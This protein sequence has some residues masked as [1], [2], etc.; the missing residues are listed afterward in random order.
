[1]WGGVWGLIALS[2]VVGGTLNHWL[3]M[4]IHECT[5]ELAARTHRGNRWLAMLAGLP[6]VAPA[7]MAFWHHHQAHHAFLGIEGGD[8]DLPS[9]GEVGWVGN[10]SLRKATWLLTLPLTAPFTRG[11]MVP[12]KYWERIN[13]AV[14]LAANVAIVYWLGWRA[15]AYFA[16]STFFG[17]GLHPAAAHW[18]HEHYT[19]DGTQE[20][21]SYYGPLNWLTFNVGY[22]TEH[23]DLPKIPGWKLPELHRIARPFYA[24]QQSHRSWLGVL[25]RFITRPETSHAS[26]ITRTVRTWQNAR[27]PKAQHAQRIKAAGALNHQDSLIAPPAPIETS[28]SLVTDLSHHASQSS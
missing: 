6:G 5:H 11:F 7:A 21:F 12:P 4:G 19:D 9:R 2:Y 24:N 26:R 8:N 25:W 3:A 10:S 15:L 18:I 20:T 23:H 14:Q 28:L 1:M 27:K 13:I 16:L 17:N 22:H